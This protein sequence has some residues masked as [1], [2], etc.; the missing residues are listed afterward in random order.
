MRTGLTS[1][2]L[3]DMLLAMF[4]GACIGAADLARPDP[5]ESATIRFGPVGINPSLAIRD[6][7]VDNNVFHDDDGSEIRLHLHG[8]AAS[9]RPVQP[10]APAPRLL[11]VCR[12]RVLPD[13][14]QRGEAPIALPRSRPTWI[15][16]ASSRTPRSP[17]SNT[18]AALQQRDGHTRPPSRSHIQ[19]GRGAARGVADLDFSAPSGGR[20]P[21]STRA[22][23]FVARI[24]RE[25]LNNGN[26]GGGRERRHAADTADVGQPG[27]LPRMAAV[28]SR[29]SG[30]PTPHE[31]P[32]P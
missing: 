15:S 12:L 1:A 22:A 19:R 26:T 21:P 18:R 8:D 25:A 29:P 4:G 28:R 11:D 2:R 32:R 10:E 17:A 20:R 31:S 7:G 16:D 5:I 6:I 27:R 24:W 3:V 23:N 9:R 30:T 14:R 13:L